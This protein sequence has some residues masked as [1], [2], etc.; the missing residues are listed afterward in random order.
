VFRDRHN[1]VDDCLGM[2]K[3]REI[4][5]LSVILAPLWLCKGYVDSV[6]ILLHLCVML[7]TFPLAGIERLGEAQDSPVKK[8]CK[9]APSEHRFRAICVHRTTD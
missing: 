4:R 8:S 1:H 2:A 6:L 9:Q 5:V 3:N 7:C